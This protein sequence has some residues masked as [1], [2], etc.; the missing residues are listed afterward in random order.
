MGNGGVFEFLCIRVIFTQNP[1]FYCIK[2]K[3][4]ITSQAFCAL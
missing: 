4:R 1:H 2:M 3:R